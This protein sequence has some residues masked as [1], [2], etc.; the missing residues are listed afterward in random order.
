MSTAVYLDVDGIKKKSTEITYEDLVWLYWNFINKHN[1]VPTTSEGL[2][3]NNLPQQRIIKKILETN[4][5][6]MND[7]L[8][9][10]GKVSH[11]RTESKDYD[12]FVKRFKEESIKKG[13][14]L[15]QSE[16][17]NNSF[18]LPNS[19]WFVKYCPSSEVNTYDDFVQWC[20]FHSNKQKRDTKEIIQ[21]LSNFEKALGRPITRQDISKDTI[22]FS[23]IV[24]NRIWGSLTKCKEE[25]GLMKT[26]RS[27]PMSF[28]YY[29]NNLDIILDDYYKRTSKKFICWKDIE[30]NPFVTIGHKS[31]TDAFKR[32]GLD[33]V[34]YIRSKGFEMNPSL[35]SFHHTFEDGEI[36]VSSY[37]YD[38]TKYL[39]EQGYEYNKTYKRNV[40]YKTIAPYILKSKINCD[41]VI[42]ECWIEIA[43]II[44]NSEN[45]WE[46]HIYLSKQKQDYQKQ[47]LYKK[48]LLEDNN[49]PYIFLFPEDFINAKYKI[50]LQNLLE[51]EV[52]Y[53]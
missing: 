39:R 9:Q 25:L 18:G 19:Q 45:N 47:L 40:M 33:V 4:N 21:S 52:K 35:F 7:F 43:G 34:A 32:N 26:N 38:F 15:N 17:I 30:N 31:L 22:G 24:I 44:S 37:E 13:R 6:T 5:I 8:N 48:Q 16:L 29:K 10:F 20:G 50:K 49:I 41:Y 46:N 28:E 12:F 14:A 36:T 2:S 1:R 27:N 51:R 53:A 23:M 42:N 3:K 11:V